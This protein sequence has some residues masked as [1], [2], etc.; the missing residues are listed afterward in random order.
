MTTRVSCVQRNLILSTTAAVPIRCKWQD[1]T[2]VHGTIRLF[3][4]RR[5]QTECNRHGWFIQK[6]NRQNWHFCLAIKSLCS[7]FYY[8]ILFF[9]KWKDISN[10]RLLDI[11][12]KCIFDF[13]DNS[14]QQTVPSTSPT[15]NTVL[16][17]PQIST[18]IANDERKQTAVSSSTANIGMTTPRHRNTDSSS[19]HSANTFKQLPSESTESTTSDVEVSS[20]V[21]ASVF[22][23]SA[24]LLWHLYGFLFIRN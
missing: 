19:S 4:R 21:R 3:E 14:D 17:Q 23:F 16:N 12:L 18:P 9:F 10:D 13:N 20:S 8:F 6:R 7:W 2:Q 24:L 22:V 1:E 15:N 5:K 11:K